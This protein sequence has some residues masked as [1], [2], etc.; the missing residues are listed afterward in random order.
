VAIERDGDVVGL[1]GN[2]GKEAKCILIIYVLGISLRNGI[3]CLRNL[4][5]RG[6][7]EV[8]VVGTKDDVVAEP[9]KKRRVEER[10]REVCVP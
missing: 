3:E 10:E 9:T 4:F 7:P 5:I 8:D 2:G 1:Y 6:G